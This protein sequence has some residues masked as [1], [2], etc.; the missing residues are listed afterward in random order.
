M[1]EDVRAALLGDHEAAD[2]CGGAGGVS[3]LR[4]EQYF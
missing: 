3:V 4:G 1:I 2:G